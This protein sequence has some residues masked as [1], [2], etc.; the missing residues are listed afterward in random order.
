MNK[1]MNKITKY[2]QKNNPKVLKCKV[3]KSEIINQY[4]PENIE[5]YKK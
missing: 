1:T 2:Y 5:N 4:T 3:K